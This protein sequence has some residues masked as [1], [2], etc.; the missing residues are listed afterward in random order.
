VTG[1]FW[2]LETI[3]EATTHLSDDLKA[4]HPAIPWRDIAGFRNIAAH[5]YLMIRADRLRRILE[6]DL[7]PLTAVIGGERAGRTESRDPADG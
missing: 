4:R 5:G 1:S 6:E 2:R 7:G 3:G